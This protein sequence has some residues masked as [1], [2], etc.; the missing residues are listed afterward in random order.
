MK[1]S[2]SVLEK[3][4]AVI[5]LDVSDDQ[6]TYVGLDTDGAVVEE[7]KVTTTRTGLEKRFGGRGG[8]CLVAIEAGTHSPWVSRLLAELGC[9][10]LVANPRQIALIYRN[11]RK[12]DRL[13]A[14]NLA[15]LAR[16]D[17][18]LLHPLVHRGRQA[19]EDLAVLRSRDALVRSR[20]QLINHVRGVVKSAGER[21]PSW[22]AES[23]HHK[24]ARQLPAGLEAAL[25][26]VIEQ[27]AQLTA[28][29]K[30]YDEKVEEL[31]QKRYP[32]ALAVRQPN[33]VGPITSLAFVLTLEDA[34]RFSSSRDVPAYLGLT[35]ARRQSGASDPELP[36]SKAGDVFLRRLLVQAAHYIIGPFGKDSD[37]R[38]WGLRLAGPAV[39]KGSK[40]RRKRA[41]IAVARKLAVLLHSL[42]VSGEVYEPLRLSPSEGGRLAS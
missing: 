7:G 19:Q 27:V 3:G 21:L 37:L 22:S 2:I 40:S 18:E 11:R 29:I 14:T 1:D 16:S 39:G 17:P 25:S 28:S 20:T 6:S 5:G 31:A 34:H 35:P 4:T 38:R 9:Q 23:F 30:K 13:D 12:S 8:G 41:V 24:A 26:A 32:E 36:I 33:G 15:R 10:V 42:W